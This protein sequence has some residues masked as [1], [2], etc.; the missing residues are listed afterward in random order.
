[1]HKN[2][3]QVPQVNESLNAIKQSSKVSL[4][5]YDRINRFFACAIGQKNIGEDYTQEIAV[6]LGLPPEKFHSRHISRINHTIRCQRQLIRS[7]AF[8]KKRL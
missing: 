5:Q 1:M 6:F 2:F 4:L 3:L 7:Q 8:K